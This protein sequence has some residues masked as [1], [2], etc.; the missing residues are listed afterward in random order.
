MNTR[1]KSNNLLLF[2]LIAI[3]SA[4]NKTEN[5]HQHPGGHEEHNA[6]VYTCPM[7]PEV[8]SSQPGQC[9]KCNMNLE[10][11][12]S[13]ATVQAISPNKQ[14]LSRQATVK[15]QQD[16]NNAI[17]KTQGYIDVDRTRNQTVS[18]RFGGRI[19]KLYVKFNSQ[20]VKQ[21][22]KIMELYSPELQTIQEEHLF[23]IKSG[24]ESSL[25]EKSRERMRLLGITENQI[26]QLEKSKTATSTVTVFSPSNGFVFF[27]TQSAGSSETSESAS[28]M[29]NMGMTQGVKNE[30]T[31][32]ASTSQIREGMY[33]NEGQT[34]FSVNDLQQ[35]WAL[36]SVSGELLADIRENHPVE[37]YSESNPS[38]VLSGKVA[39]TEK[40]FE[41]GNQRFARV[42]VIL[43]N[44][45]KS[46]KINSLVTAHI[47]FNGSNSLLIPASAV[48]KTGLN[49]Y[50]WV[51]TDTTENGT[52]I[53]Q[54]RKVI[55]GVNNNG[56]TSIT[57]GLSPGEEIAM[58][59]GFM[60]DSE[61]FLNAN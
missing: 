4:C 58:E 52:G 31:F 5:K 13:D 1:K 55:A 29:N 24:A 45:D 37:I 3:F 25:V 53:F 12:T 51:K 18:A 23:L 47:A 22:E 35:V 15:L 14:V 38:K 40:V 7:H 36:V 2:L 6:A 44:S 57:N 50:V 49:S 43:S 59:A 11:K 8:V 56:M 21:G 39:L 19:E 34:I 26:T 60:T 42:R 10:L 46:L 9:P 20:S 48:Y 27:D 41:E 28:S 30:K 17:I 54:L 32:S 16:S 33:V 61:T